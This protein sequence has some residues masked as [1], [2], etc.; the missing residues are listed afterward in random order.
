M[1]RDLENK[2]LTGRNSFGVQASC[3]QLIE[4]ETS[5]DLHTIF[6]DMI[7]RCEKWMVLSGG[8]NVLFTEDYD[9]V[10][11]HPASDGIEITSQ[12]PDHTLVRVQAGVEWDD[13]VAWCAEHELWGAENLSLIPGKVGAAPIQN[14]GAY[15]TEASDIIRSVEMFCTDTLNTL[16]LDASYCGFGYRES[17]FKHS[18]KGR[19][20][21]TA[22]NF[23][24]SRKA[25][26]NLGYGALSKH[27]EELGGPTLANIRRAVI[28][29]RRSKLPDTSVTGN[30][31]SF[32]KNPIVDAS[33]A[34]NLKEKFDDMPIYPTAQEDKV[35]IA[36]GWL[37][38]KAGWKG[39]CEGAAG[40]HDRQALVLINK[41]GATGRQIIDLATRIRHDVLS[42][43]G[44]DIEPEVNI[45]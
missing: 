43:F 9:G 13:F 7:C 4:Y 22:V 44:I 2:S 29:I 31:G 28:D 5:E 16:T 24:L 19:V 11:L 40:V 15:G 20:I 45:V 14:I 37:I 42:M 10:I 27:V 17:I 3:R 6:A 23:T 1:I 38:E 18:L 26:P 8:N 25:A 36:A 33:K 39:R 12:T 30:A 35:K 41:G 32:F 21:V 34:R